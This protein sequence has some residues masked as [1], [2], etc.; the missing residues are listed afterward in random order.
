MVTERIYVLDK[1]RCKYLWKL[2]SSEFNRYC[3]D[4]MKG[5]VYDSKFMDVKWQTLVSQQF[6]TDLI[7]SFL[8]PFIFS[9]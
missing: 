8:N 3:R 2:D 6:I 5:P 1:T 9:K 4:R 7:P